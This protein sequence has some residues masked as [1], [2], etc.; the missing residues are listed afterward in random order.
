[1]ELKRQCFYR[2]NGQVK[3]KRIKAIKNK[4]GFL[5]K[6]LYFPDIFISLTW[7]FKRIFLT[8]QRKAYSLLLITRGLH[9]CK[10]SLEIPV[11]NSNFSLFS[12]RVFLMIWGNRIIKKMFDYR[13]KI[14]VTKFHH[15]PQQIS[16]RNNYL[17]PIFHN[18]H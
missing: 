5:H 18:Q 3:N 15:F 10:L 4:N 1:M 13:Y 12:P 14:Y 11:S 16:E 9:L 8:F 6:I 7:H 17:V 2:R